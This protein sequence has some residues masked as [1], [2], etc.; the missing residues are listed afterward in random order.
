[1]MTGNVESSDIR[2]A[3]GSLSCICAEV[4]FDEMDLV[5]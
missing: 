3:V 2:R 5:L 4:S 1:M